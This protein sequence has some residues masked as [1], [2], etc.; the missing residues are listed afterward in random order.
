[1]NTDVKMVT[2]TTTAKS[3]RRKAD[4]EYPTEQQGMSNFQVNDNDNGDNRRSATSESGKSLPQSK[5]PIRRCRRCR[6]PSSVFSP[7]PLP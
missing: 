3:G 7:L 4:G 1:M 6:Y 5:T 2:A